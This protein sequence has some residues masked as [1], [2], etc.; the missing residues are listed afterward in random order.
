MRQS[1]SMWHS[2]ANYSMRAAVV[3]SLLS[4]SLLPCHLNAQSGQRCEEL[5]VHT[6][7][8][9]YTAGEALRYTAR[10]RMQ[11]GLSMQSRIVYFELLQPETQKAYRWKMNVKN[12]WISGEY[13]LPLDIPEG[14]YLFSAHT[15]AMKNCFADASFYKP[16]LI[17]TLGKQTEDT[18]YLPA[19]VSDLSSTPG[20]SGELSLNVQAER[21]VLQAGKTSQVKL[22]G[23]AW[24]AGVAADVSL[25][26]FWCPPRM[27]SLVDIALACV[28]QP[29]GASVTKPVRGLYPVEQRGFVLR[30]R[31]T[32][33]SSG[34]PLVNAGMLMAVPDTVLPQFHF[35]LTDSSGGFVFFPGRNF[36]NRQLIIQTLE[37]TEPLL[38]SWELEEKAATGMQVEVEP[39]VLTPEEK[40]IHHEMRDV[41]IV[42]AIYSSPSGQSPRTTEPVRFDY[43]GEP[44][45]RIRPAD[46]AEML[47]FKDMADNILPFVRIAT[48]GKQYRLELLNERAG[49]WYGGN[50]V[51]LNG[52][53]FSDLDYLASMGSKD[54][55]RIDVYTSRFFLGTKQ[56][57][58]IMAV[59][60]HSG[61]IPEDYLKSHALSFFNEIIE[62]SFY[63]EYTENTRDDSQPDFRHVLCWLPMLEIK[64]ETP[65]TIPF[66]SSLLAGSYRVVAR[67]FT[68]GG[69]PVFGASSFE[70]LPHE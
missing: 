46:Y 4:L 30:G 58:G 29:K 6:D 51:L 69:V 55:S 49:K 59:Y 28:Y 53:P 65:V 12:G 15:S 8:P 3:L 57:N 19:C 44:D 20:R 61:L 17:L 40:A 37:D 9:Y 36:D 10:F 26:V 39:I 54:I 25:A 43:L 31:V 1:Y 24:P 34:R 11:E 62:P 42:H 32:Y 22:D 38:L 35:A 50:L 23:T 5:Q 56:Y 60:T 47:S 45:N 16:L 13:F 18:L 67:G 68:S 64:A 70:V 52:I 33:L 7:R 21:R 48:A 14:V 27:D 2:L 66:R 41:S 63:K